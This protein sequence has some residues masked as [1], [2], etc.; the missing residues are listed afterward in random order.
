[1]D[2]GGKAIVELVDVESREDFTDR[3]A[4]TRRKLAAKAETTRKR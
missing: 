4:N 1:M 3:I 2:P